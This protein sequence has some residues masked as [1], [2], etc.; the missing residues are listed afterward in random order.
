MTER[1]VSPRKPVPPKGSSPGHRKKVSLMTE[2]LAAAGGA[3]PKDVMLATMREL[4]AGAEN[5]KS[6]ATRRRL[7]RAASDV[8]KDAAPYV[9]PKLATVTHQGGDKP[10]EFTEVRRTIVRPGEV[11]GG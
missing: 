1:K 2:A 3:T 7:M 8:A 11:Q 5:A 4:V 6:P 10:I 9:H